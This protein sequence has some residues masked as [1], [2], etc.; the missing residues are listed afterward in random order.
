M[1]MGNHYH[2]FLETPEPNL[3]RGQAVA[4][5]RL[6]TPVQLAARLHMKTAAGVSQIVRRATIPHQ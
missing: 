5:E 3:A 2:E 1:L 6:Y 4:S